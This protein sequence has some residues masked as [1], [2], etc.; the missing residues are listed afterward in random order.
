MK[1]YRT[2]QLTFLALLIPV[3]TFA[4]EN[5]ALH[6][7]GVNDYVEMASPIS[8]SSDFSF[9][10]WF[11]SEPNGLNFKRLVSMNGPNTRFEIG[12]D[13]QNV[14]YFVHPDNTGGGHT[15]ARN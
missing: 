7:D 6:F 10:A 12:V 13:N 4:Q 2:I 15:T 9:E 14:A 11:Q 5:H 3:M 1:L 8:G